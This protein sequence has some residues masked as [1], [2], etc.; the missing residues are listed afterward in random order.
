MYYWSDQC[1]AAHFKGGHG[2]I[3]QITLYLVNPAQETTGP[4]V[5]NAENAELDEN[6]RLVNRHLPLLLVKTQR[7]KQGTRK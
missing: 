4:R 7:R 6:K 5:I 1:H 3:D 2:L